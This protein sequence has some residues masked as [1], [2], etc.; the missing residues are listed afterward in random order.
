LRDVVRAGEKKKTGMGRCNCFVD[1]RLRSRELTLSPRMNR[2]ARDLRK[3]GQRF[4]DKEPWEWSD[5]RLSTGEGVSPGSF[6]SAT[7]VSSHE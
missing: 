7:E 2:L 4:A 5:Y 3:G 6:T 1:Q